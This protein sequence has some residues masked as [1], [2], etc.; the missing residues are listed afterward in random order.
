MIAFNDVK[1]N[2]VLQRGWDSSFP[3][4]L[5]RLSVVLAILEQCQSQPCN[6]SARVSAGTAGAYTVYTCC[7]VSLIRWLAKETVTAKAL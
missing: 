2:T 4:P 6:V 1:T 3:I 5:Q 7:L